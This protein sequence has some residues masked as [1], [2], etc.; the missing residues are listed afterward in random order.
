MSGGDRSVRP[1]ALV[2]AIQSLEPLT[3]WR[4]HGW[5]RSPTNPCGTEAASGELE[6][7]NDLWTPFVTKVTHHTGWEE[8][9]GDS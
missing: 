1:L 6:G 7:S 2:L 8:E 9:A 4:G 3:G 5:S